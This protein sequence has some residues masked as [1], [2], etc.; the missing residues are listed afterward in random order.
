MSTVR[1]ENMDPNKCTEFLHSKFHARHFMLTVNSYSLAVS[2][3]SLNMLPTA[4]CFSLSAALTPSGFFFDARVLL[5]SVTKERT[6]M[7]IFWR[8]KHTLEHDHIGI[9]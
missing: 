4:M 7:I 1:Y 3:C 9:V 8:V 5:Y 2:L 6:L